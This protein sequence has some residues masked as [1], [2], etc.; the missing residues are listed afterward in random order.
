M[1]TPRRPQRPRRDR[2]ARGW[3]DPT[4]L[5]SRSWLEHPAWLAT[6]CVLVATLMRIWRI[7]GALPEG[8]LAATPVRDAWAMLDPITGGLANHAAVS[9]TLASA[10][11]LG[12]Q[13]LLYLAG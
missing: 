9:T 7:D 11:H 10:I 12:V 3:S 8:P 13:K 1:P 5:G 6:G 2:H 4:P